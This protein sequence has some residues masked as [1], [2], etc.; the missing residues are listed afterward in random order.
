VS[1][2]SITHDRLELKFKMR[3]A[4][5]PMFTKSVLEHIAEHRFEGEGANRLPRARHFVTTIYFDTPSLDLYRAVHNNEDNLK[6]RAREYYDLH[7]E[8][9]EL[10]TSQ[11]Q[12]VRYHPVLWVEIKGKQGGR[13]Y[14]RR[15]GI[16]KADVGA[17][18]EHGTVSDAMLSLEGASAT[19]KA[20]HV[21][22]ELLELR[23][24]FQQALRPSCL[25][26]YRR[27]AFQDHRGSLRITLDQRLGC[28][29][30]PPD[31]LDHHRPLLRDHLGPPRYE[32]PA[33]VLEIKLTGA[34][35]EWLEAL[36]EATHAERFSFSKF[37]TASEAVYGADA[38]ARATTQ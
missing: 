4:H 14:K 33:V 12:I 17:F 24:R 29:A 30:V 1:T 13:T 35:P 36:M 38:R 16:P 7:P 26:N 5:A 34:M 6:V 23:Q 31:L 8:L 32:E 3:A 15:V 27:T 18:F 2:A 37:V 25:V 22:A 28:F 10:A 21:I 20:P 11:S 19:P 9:L